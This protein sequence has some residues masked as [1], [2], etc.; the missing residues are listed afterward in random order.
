MLDSRVLLWIASRDGCH[1]FDE[2]YGV[3][4]HFNTEKGLPNNIVRK[5]LES[6]D[7]TIWIGTDNGLC[8]LHV[9]NGRYSFDVFKNEK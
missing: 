4:R 9:K 6:S 7:G 8:R 2:R 5:V 3:Y 1:L